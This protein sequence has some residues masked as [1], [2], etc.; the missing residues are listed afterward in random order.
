MRHLEARSAGGSAKRATAD[1]SRDRNDN[2]LDEPEL[3]EQV[4]I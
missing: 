3:W 1:P 4:K 2:P